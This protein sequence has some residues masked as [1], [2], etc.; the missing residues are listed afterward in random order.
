MFSH[1]GRWLATVSYADHTVGLWDMTA[2]GSSSSV[3]KLTH[4]NPVPEDVL[5]AIAFSPD[6]RQLAVTFGYLVQLWDLTAADPCATPLLQGD[7][8]KWIQAVGFSPDGHWLATAGQA[9]VVKPWELSARDPGA[10][11]I[12]LPG[13]RAAV[14]TLAFSSTGR[15]LDTAG[16]DATVRLWDLTDPTIPSVPSDE[17]SSQSDLAI[18]SEQWQQWGMRTRSRRQG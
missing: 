11:P 15:W 2:P 4:R 3:R 10:R 18:G 12:P 1:T 8:K 14:K 17:S 16:Q 7:R 5:N 6:E 13:H 9:T